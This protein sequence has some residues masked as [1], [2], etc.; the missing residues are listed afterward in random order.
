MKAIFLDIET[1][2]LDPCLH[3]VVEIAFKVVDLNTGYEVLTYQSVVK[4]SQ[5]VWNLKDP[6]SVEINGF[7]WEK[8]QFGKEESLVAQEIIQIFVDLQIAR[9]RTVYI[10]QNPAFDRNF[11]SQIVDINTQE[12]YQWP[13]HWLD[14]ASMYWALQMKIYQEKRE[15]LPEELCISKN[16]IAQ[17]HKLPVEMVPHCALNGVDHLIHCYRI[18]VG[19]GHYASAPVSKP[20][21]EQEGWDPLCD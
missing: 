4:Q 20:A 14:F 5:A 9:H 21:A 1:T 19:I 18:V 3:R 15:L 17:Q 16:A 11:F 7:T 8:L 10:C 13:Y 6:R 12:K 2:G